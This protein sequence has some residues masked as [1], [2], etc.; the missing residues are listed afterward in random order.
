VTNM[1]N[2]KDLLLASLATL[3]TGTICLQASFTGVPDA[4]VL[5]GLVASVAAGPVILWYRGTQPL[6]PISA[7]YVMLISIALLFIGFDLAWRRGLVEF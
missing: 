5:V 3:I 4:V 2:V 7:A 1:K 6:I